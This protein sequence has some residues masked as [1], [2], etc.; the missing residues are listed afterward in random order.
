MPVVYRGPYE[1]GAPGR[2]DDFWPQHVPEVPAVPEPQPAPRV[3]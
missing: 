3:A 1:Y 2:D